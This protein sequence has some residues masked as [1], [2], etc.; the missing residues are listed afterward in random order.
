MK[1]QNPRTSGEGFLFIGLSPLFIKRPLKGELLK[2]QYR[3]CVIGF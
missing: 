2:I 1:N 3:I